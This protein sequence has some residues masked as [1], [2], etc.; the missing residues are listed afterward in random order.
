MSHNRITVLNEKYIDF[1]IL[2]I[3]MFLGTHILTFYQ[4]CVRFSLS[5][6]LLLTKTYL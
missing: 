5:W 2:N 4:F 6:L 3:Y 1:F